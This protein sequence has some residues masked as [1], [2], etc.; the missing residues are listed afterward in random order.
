MT[1]HPH[2]LH[3][4]I[5]TRR[6]RVPRWARQGASWPVDVAWTLGWAAVILGELVAERWAEGAAWWRA[7]RA[8]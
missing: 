1:T 6:L 4:P 7:R 5:R 8:R 2:G 3:T